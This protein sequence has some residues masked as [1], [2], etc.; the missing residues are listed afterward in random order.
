MENKENPENKLNLEPENRLNLKKLYEL[1]IFKKFK[2]QQKKTQVQYYKDHGCPEEI[3]EFFVRDVQGK[4]FGEKLME[5]ITREIFKMDPRDDSTHD[6]KKMGKKIEQK[7]ARYHANGQD[8]KWQHIEMEHDWNFI[9]IAG[10]DFQEILHFIATR[11][12]IESL[13]SMGIITGQGKKS[14]NGV[15]NPQQGYW[16][17]RSDFKKYGKCFLDYFHEIRDENELVQFIESQIITLP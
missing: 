3:I 15:A 4:T 2:D 17:S 5:P 16:F 11:E 8:W 12:T 9:I 13:I 7:S 6:H 10:L 14:E 1:E